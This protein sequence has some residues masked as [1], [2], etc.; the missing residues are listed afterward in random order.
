ML[1]KETILGIKPAPQTYKSALWGGELQYRP[2]SSLDRMD[3]KAKAKVIL[4]LSGDRDIS[5]EHIEAATFMTCVLDPQF[6]PADMIE[7]MKQPGAAAEISA[8]FELI[9]RRAQGNP[10]K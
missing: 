10:T 4:E 9:M 1:T 3:A 2:A 7:L 8:V 6:S 5:V